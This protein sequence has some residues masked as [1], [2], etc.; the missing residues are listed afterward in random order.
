MWQVNILLGH[1]YS[2]GEYGTCSKRNI[3]IRLTRFCWLQWRHN[4]RGSVSNHQRLHF[5]PNCRFRRR[6]KK[7]S[8][9]RVTVLLCGEYSPHKRPVTR[10]MFPFDDIIMFWIGAMIKGRFTSQWVNN[11][12]GVKQFTV[13]C[14]F[15][16]IYHVTAR[17]TM[18]EWSVSAIS[19]GGSYRRLVHLAP[20]RGWT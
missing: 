2:W 18:T 20:T 13:T 19:G 1:I 6:S 16:C 14:Y 5:L 3:N 9:L 10:K 15:V 12:T 11:H 17:L 8:K 4:E 7:T